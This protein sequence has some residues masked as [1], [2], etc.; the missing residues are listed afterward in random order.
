M[1]E[2]F[3]T[4]LWMIFASMTME[5]VFI[6]TWVGAILVGCILGFLGYWIFEKNNKENDH[7]R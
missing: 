5:E 3:T 4:P 6:V 1:K 7:E 2:T